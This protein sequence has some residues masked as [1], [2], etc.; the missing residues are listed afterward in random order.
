MPDSSSEAQSLSFVCEKLD[1]LSLDYLTLLQDY[2][3][4]AL[5]AQSLQQEGNIHLAK[6]RY[7]E[8]PN[9]LS[10]V[11]LPAEETEATLRVLR[12]EEG[13]RSLSSAVKE[14]KAPFGTFAGQDKKAAAS[15]FTRSL[16]VSLERADVAD[17]LL[18]TREQIQS[19]KTLKDQLVSR[20]EE[21][22]LPS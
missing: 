22:P 5:A 21:L 6:A 9:L 11:R 13:G 20:G 1:A 17:K 18:N 15:M 4:L 7:L 19:L 12:T 3:N 16:S 8:G 14:G 2:V 10:K